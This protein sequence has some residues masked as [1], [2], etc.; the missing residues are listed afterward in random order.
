MWDSAGSMVTE[1]MPTS[2]PMISADGAADVADADGVEA[3]VEPAPGDTVTTMDVH[4]DDN[5]L[6]ITPDAEM[7][8][9]TDAAQFPLYLD[10]PVGWGEA[11][12][13][14]L[15]SDGYHSYAWGNGD[16]DLGKGVGKCGTWN[17][18]S[19]GAGYVQRLYFEFSPASLKGKQVLDA[20]FR[21]TEPWAFQCDPRWVDLVRT[22]NISTSTTWASRP[23]ELDLMVDRNV[24]AGRG[25]ACD[26]DSPAAPIEFNDNAEETNENLTS[27][28]KSFAAGKFS[29]FTLELSAH[30]E[31]DTS[32]WK[33]FRNDATLWVSYV[34]L[35]DVPTSPTV[36]SSCENSGSDPAW[37]SNPKPMFKAEVQ[38]A[39]GGESEASL[40][41]HFDIQKHASD[42]TLTP[43]TGPLGPSSG[44][45]GDNTLVG[46]S[47]P[48]TL[49]QNTLYQMR[50]FTRS[51][52]NSGAN[53]VESAHSTVTS[54]GWCY[55][56]IDSTGP[57]APTVTA[58]EG[59]LYQVCADEGDGCGQATGAP[60]RAGQ[61]T[62]T[63]NSADSNIA[64][65]Q[66]KLATDKAW[67][68]VT[69]TSSITVS[70]TPQLAGVQLLNV[71][72]VDSVGTGQAGET[73]TIRF[74]VAEGEGPSGLWHFSDGSVGSGVKTA[75]DTGTAPG[76]R[77][78]LTL[79]AGGVDWSPQGRLGGD[80]RSL[81]FDNS[82]QG[83][84]ATLSPVINT[85][86]SFTVSAWT[87]LRDTTQHRTVLSQ[88]GSDNKGILLYYSHVTS[89]WIFMFRWYDADGTQQYAAARADASPGITLNTW[90]HVAG[91]YDAE[92]HTVS[93]FVNGQRQGDPVPVPAAGLPTSVDGSFQIGRAA[94]TYGGSFTDY[95]T[96]NLD[97]VATFQ[98]DLPDAEVAKVAKLL[99]ADDT[100]RAVELVAD[101]EPQGSTGTA[102]LT[103]T[104]SGYGR[105]LQMN[106]DAKVEDDAIILDGNGDSVTTPGPVVDDRESF[107]V[108][109]EVEMDATALVGDTAQILG[110]R[111]ADGA[112]WGLWYQRT[113]SEEYMDEETGELVSRP[114]GFWRF[115]RL[116]SDGSFTAVDSEEAASDGAVRLTGVYDAQDRVIRLY[117]ASMQNGVN[118][119]YTAVIGSDEFA[120]GKGFVN[121]AWD[122]YLPGKITDIRIWVGAAKDG[123]QV[124]DLV[125]VTQ[126]DAS[127]DVSG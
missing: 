10:P 96:G 125:G 81:T 51:Y 6:T 11:E 17:G 86:S 15:R 18:Y 68:P 70:V 31:S 39:S 48:V 112:A 66:Y 58:P 127:D 44:Y 97:E 16:D 59:A 61:F 87:N 37:M 119:A 107:T 41:A 115:G 88:N 40:R 13:T 101:W 105:T 19:C 117:L 89:K 54:T 79:S 53:Y 98:T 29:R 100:E 1:S 23:A 42:G 5:S 9:G 106:G 8:T 22:N 38:A 69:A 20:T 35:P 32:A 94:T 49:E 114:I 28:V 113:G 104:V 3:G 45:V 26:P 46:V 124:G 34:G 123:D 82:G 122:H 118:T 25:S 110:Q 77:H 111:T 7:L 30:D 36:G 91:V 99:N 60:G 73:T 71:R 92:A 65:F 75:A 56:K 27:T 93:V 21:V 74:N 126:D 90:T 85:Q 83:Y 120:V 78:N 64:S 2:Q 95:W 52:Y 4:V 108:T 12:R 43:V 109:T 67:K 103:D 47:S 50:V 63:K 57:K 62:F 33:R 102:P 80:D 24:S 121:S 72:A 76:T 55:F 84:A 14:L 116:N